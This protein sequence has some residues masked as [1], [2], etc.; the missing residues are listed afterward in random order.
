MHPDLRDHQLRD[1]DGLPQVQ[2]PHKGGEAPAQRR[3][4]YA[5]GAYRGNPRHVIQRL[6]PSQPVV[7]KMVIKRPPEER[8]PPRRKASG[9]NIR[10][11]S[12]E[13][14]FLLSLFRSF[15]QVERGRSLSPLMTLR[16]VW[17]L[18]GRRRSRGAPDAGSSP[19]SLS[20][21]QTHLRP[22]GNPSR[23]PVGGN[24]TSSP[25]HGDAGAENSRDPFPPVRSEDES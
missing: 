18:S 10:K 3:T 25:R 24:Q 6:V 13:L 21:W 7:Q 9:L 16:M 12:G 8:K 4:Q 19:L 20:S 5:A 11:T 22:R 14:A 15:R 2:V 17:C 1:R 23:G